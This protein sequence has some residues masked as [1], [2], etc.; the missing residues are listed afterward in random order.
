MR[1]CAPSIP[2]SAEC[3]SNNSASRVCARVCVTCQTARTSA[4]SG[5][6][7]SSEDDLREMQEVE[8]HLGSPALESAAEAAAAS[9]VMDAAA[10]ADPVSEDMGSEATIRYQRAKLR[11]LEQEIEKVVAENKNTSRAL[12]EE[13]QQRKTESEAHEKLQKRVRSLEV[14]AEKQ[15]KRA[16]FNTRKLETAELEL[17]A[18]KKELEVALRAQ[19]T[20]SGESSTKDVRINRAMEELEKYKGLLRERKAQEKDKEDGVK[21]EIER[22]SRENRKLE[23][24]KTE[25]IAAFRKQMKLIDVLKRQKLHVEAARMLAFTEEEFAA[26]L[27]VGER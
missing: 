7:A 3:H 23:K 19:K 1:W 26:T 14:E 5:G 8:D 22:L 11:V 16:D 20:V 21:G 10:D 18:V 15:R 2:C 12:G 9:A 27:E 17:A 6:L 13:R 24:Q 25:L 4:D